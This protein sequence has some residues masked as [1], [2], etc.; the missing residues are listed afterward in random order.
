MYAG[1]IF[2]TAAMYQALRA[3]TGT[4][5]WVF[6][7]PGDVLDVIGDRIFRSTEPENLLPIALVTVV[8][9]IAGSVFVLER[10]VRGVEV[11]T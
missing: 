3:I 2:F 11:V 9:L 4:R 7:S 6:I 8:V 10:R 1:L 5:A